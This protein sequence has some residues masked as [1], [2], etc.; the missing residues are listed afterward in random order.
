MLFRLFVKEWE[1]KDNGRLTNICKELS[2]YPKNS[3]LYVGNLHKEIYKGFIKEYFENMITSEYSYEENE[4][5][6][7]AIPVFQTKYE[8]KNEVKYISEILVFSASS[9]M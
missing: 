2:T 4:N 9:I 5:N 1:N 6:P 3:I 7:K 8:F